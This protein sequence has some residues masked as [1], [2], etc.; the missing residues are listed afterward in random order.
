[1]LISA[2]QLRNGTH[3]RWL[4]DQIIGALLALLIVAIV[5]ASLAMASFWLPIEHVTI[6]YL[7]PV[8]VAAFRWGA[9]PAM[10]A[11]ISGIA[12]PA[13]FF[14]DP[15]YDF[16]VQSPTAL[17]DL[18]LFVTVATIT[19]R[20]AV[21]VRYAKL[22][23]QAE[24]LRDAL[25]G[26]VSHELR[27]PLA[28]IVGSTSVLAQSP[29]VE[30]DPHLSSLV[31]VVRTEAER[32]N[33]DIQNL[34]EAT[35]I[36]SDGIQPHWEWVD[37]EDVVSAAL[38]RR[39]QLLTGRD[40]VLAVADDLP[41]VYVDPSL[42]QNVLGQLIENATKY[43]AAGTPIRVG[44]Q[45]VGKSVH[46]EVQD[47]GGGL[48]VGE[49]ERIFEQFYRSPR[50]AGIIPGSGLGLWIARSLTEACGGSVQAFSGGL[51]QG[52]TLSITLPVK[53]QPAADEHADE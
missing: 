40:I 48:T 20:M 53:P 8:I 35:R 10:V 27:T 7:I 41:L 42:I 49:E 31:R 1:M 37:P 3:G 5:T 4:M 46:I 22:R 51:G 26:S 44:A 47:Q 13:F 17:A 9:I 32:L 21:T 39:R 16:R 6:A 52:T 45:Q 14:Y 50:H 19:G 29:A 34:L 38:A 43:S 25:I 12:A 30:Q 18:V 24:S 36:S 23:A 11:G 15:V 28:A 2:R 33:G